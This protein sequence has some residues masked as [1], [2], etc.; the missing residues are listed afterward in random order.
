MLPSTTFDKVRIVVRRSKIL[1]DFLHRL[2]N[3][4]DTSKHIR[5]TFVGE[6]AVD[7]G[8]PLREYFRLVLKA[9][10]TSNSLFCG[11][12]GN[13]TPNHN[14]T[15]LKKKTFY[16]VGVLIALSLVHGGPAP[17]FFSPAVADYIIYGV[18]N[19]RTTIED[20]PQPG[21]RQCLQKV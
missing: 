13:R 9:I 8:G 17:H 19:V 7:E 21:I 6:P 12:D 3:G 16:D 14:V 18:Q 5:V 15:E 11:L 1:Y 2:R 20:V 10:S 4:L